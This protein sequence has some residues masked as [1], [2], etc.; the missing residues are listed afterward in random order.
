[1]YY[2]KLLRVREWIKNVFLFIPIFF[3][4]NIFDIDSLVRLLFGFLSFSLIASSIYIINDYQD[5]E[6][7]KVHP[8]KRH[9][10]F[11]S[12]EVSLLNAFLLVIFLMIASFSISYIIDKSFFVV[13]LLYFLMNIFYSLGLKHISIL[14]LIIIALGFILRVVSGGLIADV[15]I[16][17]WLIIMIFLLA[18]FLGFAKRRDDVLIKNSTGIAIRKSAQKYNLDFINASLIMISAIII[19]SYIMYTV[20]PEIQKQFSNKVYFTTFFVFIGIL[21]YL[22]LIF[23]ENRTGSPTEILLKDRT[24]QMLIILWILSFYVIIYI[25][26]ITI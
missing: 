15:A 20:S 12:G 3:S 7:D 17:N 21:R 8:I 25:K 14:D 10:P 13:I 11:P 4:G 5:R 2:L 6:I 22:Q 24:I 19:V 16:S 9:R 18:V 23:V 1:M 26:D